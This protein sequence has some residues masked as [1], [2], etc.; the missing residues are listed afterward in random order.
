MKPTGSY[1]SPRL[2]H[3]SPRPNG[4]VRGGSFSGGTAPGYSR[5]ALSGLDRKLRPC[6][7]PRCGILLTEPSA[8]RGFLGGLVRL[9]ELAS[10]IISMHRITTSCLPR[11][12]RKSVSLT[13]LKLLRYADYTSKLSLRTGCP[14]TL[15]KL[16]TVRRSPAWH[17]SKEMIRAI[18]FLL[19]LFSV[20]LTSQQ[21]LYDRRV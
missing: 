9:D 3:P 19:T 2:R 1:P 15:L 12:A 17:P 20:L 16:W 21:F 13:S 5:Y 18:A 7:I 10:P 11:L 4:V 14:A 8:L 6:S